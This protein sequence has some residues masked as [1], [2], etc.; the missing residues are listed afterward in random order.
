[1]VIT[2]LGGHLVVVLAVM[3]PFWI[4]K[5]RAGAQI[6]FTAMLSALFTDYLKVFLGHPRPYYVYAE[7]DP[8]LGSNGFGMPSGHAS[9]AT[10]VWG[11]IALLSKRK[12][13]YALAILLVF[14]VGASRVYFGVH[15]LGQ[16]VGGW[17]VGVAVVLVVYKARRPALGVFRRLSNGRW[18]WHISALA[19]LLFFLHTTIL[20]DHASRIELPSL[21]EERFVEAREREGR[22]I[23]NG[24]GDHEV[25]SLSAYEPSWARGGFIMGMW[26]LIILV[27]RKEKQRPVLGMERLAAPAVGLVFLVALFVLFIAAEGRLVAEVAISA[28]APL[29][30]GWAGPQVGRLLC[31]QSAKVSN[32]ILR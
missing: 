26:L 19:I 28:A 18:L 22:A 17:V 29:V 10:S 4:G 13:V 5:P 2:G 14:L 11:S 23:N 8:L 9:T 20:V 7:V 21:W 3:V 12:A 27:S 1:M 16:I 30:S 15:S 24:V 6:F 32:C 25:E 31:L